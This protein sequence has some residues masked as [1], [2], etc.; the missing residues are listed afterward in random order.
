MSTARRYWL[1]STVV[2]AFLVALG[3]SVQILISSALEGHRS[4][5]NVAW[6]AAQ[7]EIEYLQFKH[8]FHGYVGVS[9]SVPATFLAT[10]FSVFQNRI[11]VLKQETDPTELAADP[12]YDKLIADLDKAIAAGSPIKQALASSDP[13]TRRAALNRLAQLDSP[14]RS[15]V[16]DVMLHSNP[17]RQKE[18][19]IAAEL[20]AAGVMAVATLAGIALIAIL[21]RNIKRLEASREREREARIR[22]D[23]ASRVKDTF[24]AVVTHELRTPLNAVIGFSEL[25][26]SRAGKS[27]DKEVAAWTDEVLMAGKHLLT[28]VNQTIDMSKISAGK[29]ALSPA[30]FDLR[31]LVADSVTS[32]RRQIQGDAVNGG[33]PQL[34]TT[35]PTQDLM[36]CADE[37]WLRQALL[38]AIQHG[39][40]NTPGTKPIQINVSQ[41]SG[42]AVIDIG[43]S[44]IVG[45]DACGA[46]MNA[47]IDPFLQGELGLSRATHGLGLELPIAKAIVEAHDG[48]LR[49]ETSPD[50]FRVVINLPVNLPA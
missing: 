46:G 26:K 50:A 21:L 35:L 6:A 40:R 8:A 38:N 47:A 39:R 15:W 19:L 2:V 24:L 25:M 4:L 16:Q 32:I 30:V 9:Q 31:S 34:I 18:E 1:V 11:R 29:M 42:Q 28:L 36:I 41:R 23:H 44:G 13:G 49:Y 33:Q 5:K 43:N 12:S 7:L 14:I 37:A 27:Q 22:V 3:I 17:D 10:R 20:K 48:T 45:T